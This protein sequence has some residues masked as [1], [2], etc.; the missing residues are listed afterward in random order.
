MSCFND[1][2]TDE[3]EVLQSIFPDEYEQLETPNKFKIHI[4]PGGDEVH[5][6]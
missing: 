5:G 1:D 4:N 6:K 2:Q 3:I